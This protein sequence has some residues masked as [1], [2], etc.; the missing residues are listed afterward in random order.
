MPRIIETNPKILG[1]QPV[2]TGTRIPVARIVAL[3]VQGYKLED[4]K[5][6]YPYLNITK[7][8]LLTIFKYYQRQLA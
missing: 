4:F 5:K 7:N 1:G 2:I 3:V 8:D 6:E